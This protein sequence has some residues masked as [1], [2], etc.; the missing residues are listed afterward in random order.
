ME[1]GARVPVHEIP[2]S[3][4]VRPLDLVDVSLAVSPRE[5]LEGRRQR[6][7]GDGLPIGGSLP[8]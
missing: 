1:Q 8:G 2:L 5:G 3:Y 4:L 7:H 6:D